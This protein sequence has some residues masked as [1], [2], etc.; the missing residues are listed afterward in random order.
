MSLLMQNRK[1]K[2]FVFIMLNYKIRRKARMLIFQASFIHQSTRINYIL[3]NS[4]SILRF[5]AVTVSF[6][7]FISSITFIDGTND[8]LHFFG[9]ESK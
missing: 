3:L 6:L 1:I 4:K 5:A 9:R 7:A 2:R 8:I